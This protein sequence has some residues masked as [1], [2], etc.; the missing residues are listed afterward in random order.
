MIKAVLFDMD[1]TLIDTFGTMAKNN[2]NP[3]WIKKY[4]QKQID[5]LPSYSYSEIMNVFDTDPLLRLFPKKGK[6]AFDQHLLQ[7]YKNATLKPGALAFLQHLKQSGYII[8]LC[9]NNARHIMEQV[10]EFH[11]LDPFFDHIITCDDVQKPK[12]DPEMY[13]TA[14]TFCHVEKQECIIFEDMLEGVQAGVNAGIPVIAIEDPFSQKNRE[15]IA[16]LA[17]MMIQD[18]TDSSLLSLFPPIQS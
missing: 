1:G 11:H 13:V 14:A 17:K 15:V 12:P 8:C 4:T 2:H 7:T 6:K 18:Y 5:K 3:S 10:L 16:S 9:T